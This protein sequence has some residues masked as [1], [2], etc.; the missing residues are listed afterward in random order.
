MFA[1]QK[2]DLV[3]AWDAASLCGKSAVDNERMTNHEACC[4]TAQPKNGGGDFLW[5]A[6]PPDRQI[7]QE[8]FPGDRLRGYH[9]R[10]H[11]R[12]DSSRAHGI[13]A[14]ASSGIFERSALGQ[15]EHA[16]LGCM[17]DG[18]AGDADQAANGRAVDNRP[19]ALLAHLA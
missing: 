10:N 13:D 14:N 16:V 6:K 15:P 12:L 18:S 3:L 7:A 4:W 1:D 11:W 2:D 5:P 9:I 8:V 19:A 17:V